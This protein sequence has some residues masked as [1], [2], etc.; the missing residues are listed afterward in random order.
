[1]GTCNPPE[2]QKCKNII[3]WSGN[4][5]MDQYVSCWLSK[6]EMNLGTIL[7]RFEDFCI[8]QSNEV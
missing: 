2:C 7:E 3:A 5:G 4:F 6:E 1:M 8:P